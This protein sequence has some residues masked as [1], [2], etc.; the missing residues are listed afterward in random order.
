[1]ILW[2]CGVLYRSN[3]HNPPSFSPTGFTDICLML[4]YGSLH[5]FLSDNW[6][7]Q[8]ST[9]IAEYRWEEFHWLF[10]IF[11]FFFFG[12]S[13]LFLSYASG[14]SNLCIL[15]LSPVSGMGSL[16][17]QRSQTGPVIVWL[18]PYFLCHLY[19]STSCRKENFT[20]TLLKRKIKLHYFFPCTSS[21]YVWTFVQN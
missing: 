14:L 5:L 20:N 11:F 19:L 7:R 13:R 21:L 2:I 12:Q 1:M 17:W 6:T 10:F 18:F 16:P 3:S 9:N 15:A 4:G 8:Q